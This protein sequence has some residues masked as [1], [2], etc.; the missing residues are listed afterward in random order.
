MCHAHLALRLALSFAMSD[1]RAFQSPRTG[2]HARSFYCTFCIISAPP[3]HPSGTKK[4][5][6]LKCSRAKQA[7][8]DLDLRLELSLAISSPRAFQ[9]PQTGY[10]ARP[11]CCT[12][13]IISIPPS[14]LPGTEKRQGFN[15]GHSK[16]ASRALALR[17]RPRN[18]T[19]RRSDTLILCTFCIISCSSIPSFRHK[20]APGLQMRALQTYVTRGLSFARQKR[21]TSVNA[22]RRS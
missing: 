4:R 13:C 11:F 9:P 8:R 5:Q 20:K 22:D 7:S 18:V 10:H 21:R 3:S 1:L 19:N 2:Y 15:C 12:F 14:H 17:F 16:H 6:G